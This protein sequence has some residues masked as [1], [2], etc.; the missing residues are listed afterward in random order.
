MLRQT[1]KRALRTLRISAG[2]ALII[3][4]ILGLFLPILQGILFLV[5]GGL[6]LGRDTKPGRWFN[7]QIQR[8]VRWQKEKKETK[9]KTENKTID[10]PR[11]S[12]SKSGS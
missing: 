7:D 12:A 2:V 10:S 5:L 8:L 3:L 11:K 9:A 1:W 4:G 6:L